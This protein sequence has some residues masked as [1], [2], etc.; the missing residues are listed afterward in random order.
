[1]L[2]VAAMPLVIAVIG[3][4]VNSSLSERQN[5]ENDLRLYAE[6][7]ARREQSDSDLRKDMFKSILDKFAYATPDPKS[8]EYLDQ[9]IVNLELL[10]YNFHESI[11]LGPLF[12]HVRSEIPDGNSQSM[13]ADQSKRFENLR[14]RLERVAVEVDERQLTVVGDTGIVVRAGAVGL[15]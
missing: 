15:D 14:R 7:M 11:D 4:I 3:L 13:T 10:A 8:V 9:Q 12:K 6:M 1:I 2:K 5:V